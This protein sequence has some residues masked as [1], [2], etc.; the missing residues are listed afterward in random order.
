MNR[1]IALIVGGVAFWAAPAV[2]GVDKHSPDYL[3]QDHSWSTTFN[4]PEDV[5]A[6]FERVMRG[7][8]DCYA[9]TTKDVMMPAG[10]AFVFAGGGQKRVVVGTKAEDEKSAW[11]RIEVHGIMFG[12]MVQIDLQRIDD[13][14]KIDVYFA[15]GNHSYHVIGA[16]VGEWVKGNPTFCPEP[17]R[18]RSV[19]DRKR[20]DKILDEQSKE[21]VERETEKK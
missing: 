9:M 16:T 18:D 2:A 8:T 7:A 14:T 12:P 17:G 4:S 3:R 11:I 21:S 10:G 20:A 19:D 13:T 15:H 6:L 5:P 1:W